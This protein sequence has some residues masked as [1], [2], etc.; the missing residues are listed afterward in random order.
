MNAQPREYRVTPDSETAR[1]I[2]EAAASA[3]SI[4]VDTGE[5][6]YRVDA[7]ETT[8]PYDP[9]RMIK[10]IYASAGALKDVETDA[11]LQTL[12]AERRQDSMGRPAK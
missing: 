10:A 5:A 9:E 8:K 2:K 3:Q 4:R 1:L 11:L 7:S 6:V 12:R